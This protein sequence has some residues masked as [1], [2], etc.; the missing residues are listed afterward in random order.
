M[1]GVE[2]RQISKRFGSVLANDDVTLQVRQGEIH[3]LVGENGAGKSTLMHILY[4][5]HS[6]E[7]GTIAI[8]GTE[9]PIRK[10]ADAIRLGIGMVHQHFMLIPP[11]S[12]LENI[13]LGREELNR[14]GMLDLERS[15]ARVE[16]L[17]KAFHLE[18]DPDRTIASLSVGLQQRV[19]I[20][21]LLYREADILILDEPTPVLT[22]QEVDDLFATLQDLKRQGKTV[23]LITH[24]LGEVMSISDTVTIMRRAK[25]VT[26]LAT[27][28][29]SQ[30]EL[31]RLMVG[32]EMVPAKGKLTP[33]R[34]EIGLALH[35]VSARSD[36]GLAAVRDVTLSV[37]K[38]EILGIA[39][40]EGN[41]QSEL[42]QVVTGLRRPSSGTVHVDG[43]DETYRSRSSIAHIPED[44]LRRGIVLDFSLQENL[45]LG[46]HRERPFLGLLGFNEKAVR[47][48]AADVLRRF[49]VRPPDVRR[50]ARTLSG[51][52]Q[53][54][55]VIGREL[56]KK[57][58]V[59][60]AC[61]PTRGLDIG[62]IEFVHRTLLEQREAGKSIL[63]VSSD[64]DELL[65][66]ADRIAVMYEGE[67]VF[68]AEAAATSQRELGQYMTGAARR[69]G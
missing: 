61:Q 9:V 8:R 49:D 10:P 43:I 12:V 66:L 64:L 32:K 34:R 13:I 14:F 30:G 51:G 39:A 42:V 48:Y 16:Q 58:A 22:P 50:T 21:K 26:S 59:I 7:R 17:A 19:E 33:P 63:L 69:T 29:T 36:R 18:I 35:R 20:L 31:A 44:R 25:A 55:A 45:L 52:N 68:I 41:G 3:A 67:V 37:A 15:R 6:P 53:Q 56:S 11:L 54:K 47:T 57:T 46:R 5:L 40:V 65:S 4:G 28:T 38:G 23:I 62:A 60:V 1:F 2:M 27:R 24:K